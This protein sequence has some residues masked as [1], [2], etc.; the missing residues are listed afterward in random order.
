MHHIVHFSWTVKHKT[1]ILSC[2]IS[3]FHQ[4]SLQLLW[5]Q[6]MQIINHRFPYIFCGLHTSFVLEDWGTNLQSQATT[7]KSHCNFHFLLKEHWKVTG[8]DIS[9]TNKVPAWKMLKFKLR[10]RK[11]MNRE[12]KIKFR[13]F[14]SPQGSPLSLFLVLSSTLDP[15]D[16]LKRQ[17]GTC[18][19]QSIHKCSAL[20]CHRGLYNIKRSLAMDS[21]ARSYLDSPLL[22][23]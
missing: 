21:E 11:R 23:K 19:S 10:T 2:H 20:C 8:L 9:A 6:H 5:L 3:L 17:W 1:H 18:R 12:V 22:L 16:R 13:N 15:R 4:Q 14:P 7:S